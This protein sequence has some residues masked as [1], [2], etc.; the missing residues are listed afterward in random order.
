MAITYLKNQNLIKVG[1]TVK[2]LILILEDVVKKST[3]LYNLVYLG[4][5]K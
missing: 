3:H 1:I 5:D 2:F 4:S